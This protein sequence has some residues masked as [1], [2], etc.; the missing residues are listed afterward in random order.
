M[1]LHDDVLEP[2]LAKLKDKLMDIQV[3][4]GKIDAWVMEP[5]KCLHFLEET[6]GRYF[7]CNRRQ[8]ESISN[9]S[10]TCDI[11]EV[12]LHPT[13]HELDI[14]CGSCRSDIYTHDLKEFENVYSKYEA[15]FDI[16]KEKEQKRLI[17][18]LELLEMEEAEN[19]AS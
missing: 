10:C 13:F 19:K 9:V 16:R 15:S 14:R 17:K 6:F 12:Y 11:P 2:I 5:Q 3:C 1:L 7:E 18:L 4:L 8:Y